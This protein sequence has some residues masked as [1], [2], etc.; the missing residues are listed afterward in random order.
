[1]RYFCCFFPVK[2]V[3]FFFKKTLSEN[4]LFW[5]PFRRDFGLGKLLAHVVFF[6]LDL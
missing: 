1:M 2:S 6:L 5:C 3:I 4:P